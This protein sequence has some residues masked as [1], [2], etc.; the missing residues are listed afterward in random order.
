MRIASIAR[1]AL[2][3]AKPAIGLARWLGRKLCRHWR[4]LSAT[5][6]AMALWYGIIA[7]SSAL[8]EERRER[9]NGI[10][11]YAEHVSC[12]MGGAPL[13]EGVWEQVGRSSAAG[14]VR[15]A[16]PVCITLNATGD[17]AI[18]QGKTYLANTACIIREAKAGDCP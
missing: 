11:V 6:A 17:P 4:G 15:L 12:W 14:T 5:L 2:A 7:W 18:G 13:I 8:L 9:N 1:L 3:G 10:P 16:D